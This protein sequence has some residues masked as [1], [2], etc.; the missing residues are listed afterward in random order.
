MAQGSRRSKINQ[1]PISWLFHTWKFHLFGGEKKEPADAWLLSPFSAFF[2]FFLFFFC[3]FFTPQQ[4]NLK[5]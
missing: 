5:L 1:V 2:F 4:V 3:L